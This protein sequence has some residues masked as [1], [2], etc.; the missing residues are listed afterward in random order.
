MRYIFL[1]LFLFFFLTQVHASETDFSD[2]SSWDKMLEFDRS[3]ELQK[4]VSDAEFERTIE[5][6]KTRGKKKKN[7]KKIGAPIR[8]WSNVPE[9][10]GVKE[11]MNPTLILMFSTQTMSEDNQ[12]IPVGY[13]KIVHTNKDNAHYLS[14]F[15]G[16]SQIARLKAFET[17]ED[18]KQE[19]I[20]FV[21]LIEIDKN[22]MKLI[23]GSLDVNLEIPL[24]KWEY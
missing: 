24:R 21:N 18:Y 8:D 15:Q 14:L 2:G 4:P 23:F 3:I 22:Y 17:D 7:N 5:Q 1:S 6:L 10:Q 11:A 19:Y 16:H 20:N 12:L 9:M 13:Y